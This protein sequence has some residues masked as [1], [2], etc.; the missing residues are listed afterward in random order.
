MTQA[1]R[2]IIFWSIITTLIAVGAILQARAE[3]PA[4]GSLPAQLATL[5]I[6][7]NNDFATEEE[8]LLQG[9]ACA[10]A[11]VAFELPFAERECERAIALSPEDPIGYKYRGIAY[12]L[13]HRFERAEADLKEA[14]R[15]DPGDADSQAGYAQALSG[16]G[17]FGEA[18]ARFDIALELKPKDA[19]Y[20][21][22]RCWARGGEGK[23]FP[24]ALKDCNQAIHLKPGNAVAYDSRGFV[25]LRLGKDAQAKKDYSTALKLRPGRATA[26]LGRGIAE[27]RLGQATQ[28]AA[29]IHAARKI[30]AEVDD[31][32]I[33]AGVLQEG[34]RS[35]WGP[36]DLPVWLRPQ[37]F[38]PRPF[39]SVSY[40]KPSR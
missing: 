29:D 11:V 38:T 28:S 19:R 39:L 24:A 18:I 30:D 31:I 9:F 6:D 8:A 37:P 1:R 21:S 10:V 20:L 26:L 32:Y 22:S 4:R 40:R 33:V 7:K 3:N 16:Q 14:A 13:E 12:L 34:C 27:F 15:L 36:C 35:A 17:R 25:Y 2:R 23:D 5:K